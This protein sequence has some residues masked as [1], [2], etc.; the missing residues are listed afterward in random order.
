MIPSVSDGGEAHVALG[1]FVGF[2][3]SMSAEMNN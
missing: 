3:A 2:F 1:A